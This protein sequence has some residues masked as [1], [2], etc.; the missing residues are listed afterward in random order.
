LIGAKIWLFVGPPSSKDQIELEERLCCVTGPSSPDKPVPQTP[1]HSA[2]ISHLAGTVM[3]SDSPTSPRPASPAASSI[4]RLARPG[5]PPVRTPWS[6]S[7]AHFQITR[8]PSKQPKLTGIA[9]AVPSSPVGLRL[10][11]PEPRP[12]FGL[13]SGVA[14]R[15]EE[16]SELPYA[17]NANVDSAHA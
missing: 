4:S 1:A 8:P 12:N 13:S 17:I 11:P 14:T 5:G 2:Q 6:A 10:G 9:V 3:R 16:S 15:S 7:P